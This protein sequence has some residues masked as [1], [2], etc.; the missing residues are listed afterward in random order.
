MMS[1]RKKSSKQGYK[2]IKTKMKEQSYIPCTTAF[3]LRRW[4]KDY[5]W[6]QLCTGRTQM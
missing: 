1:T 4:V 6:S 2:D 3:A 5:T